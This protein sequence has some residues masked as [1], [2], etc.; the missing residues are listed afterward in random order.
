MEDIDQEIKF[1]CSPTFSPRCSHTYYTGTN[2][3]SSFPAFRKVLQ[4]PIVSVIREELQ[5]ERMFVVGVRQGCAPSSFQ[6]FISYDIHKVLVFLEQGQHRGW[7]VTV[8]RIWHLLILKSCGRHQ[9][10]FVL[11][12]ETTT[13]LYCLNSITYKTKFKFL[14]VIYVPNHNTRMK[15]NIAIIIS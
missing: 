12:L 4:L 7:Q 8:W 10:V 2:N 13:E 1:D 14:H 9:N 11:I 3:L 6:Q 15:W 5:V